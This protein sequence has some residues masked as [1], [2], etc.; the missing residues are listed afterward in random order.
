EDG[1]TLDH[2]RFVFRFEAAWQPGREGRHQLAF[3]EGNFELEEGAIALWL[4]SNE[5]VELLGK[6]E[7]D[8]ALQTKL[9]RDLGPGEETKRRRVPPPFAPPRASPPTPENPA[10]AETRSPSRAAT[11][12]DLLM[13]P[14]RGLWVLL[15]LAAGFGAVHALTPGHGK[16]LVAAYLV[17]Q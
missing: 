3:R 11:L 2:L 4:R 17:G 8:K 1:K 16:T 5:P 15:V 10:A 12:L 7:P 13:D 9:T 14:G 6:T